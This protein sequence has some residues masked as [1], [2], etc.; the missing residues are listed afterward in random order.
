MVLAIYTVVHVVISLVA[1]F[2]GLVVLSG[3]LRSKRLDDWTK[4]FLWA[5]LATSVTGFFFP[6]NGITPAIV[7]GII[8][9][10]V[11]APAFYAWYGRR[12]AGGWRKTYVIA[13]MIALYLNVFVLVVQSFLKIPA[14][15]SLA[16]TQAEPPFKITQLIVL[17]AFVVLTILAAIKFR[18][19]PAKQP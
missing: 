12:L 5:T 17:A 19:E 6:F 15:H 9:M 13:G 1:I 3:L 7:T 8:S 10:L 16:P 2:A 18:D 11:L 4:L 14:L